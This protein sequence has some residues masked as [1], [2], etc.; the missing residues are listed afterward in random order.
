MAIVEKSVEQ[1]EA[2]AAAKVGQEVLALFTA[3]RLRPHEA[4]EVSRLVYGTLLLAAGADPKL[5]GFNLARFLEEH[6][7]KPRVVS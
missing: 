5:A 7:D 6:T 3:K 1:E 2:S 4:L